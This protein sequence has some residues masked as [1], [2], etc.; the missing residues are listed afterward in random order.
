MSGAETEMTVEAFSKGVAIPY[1]YLEESTF[2]EAV[3]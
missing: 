2:R 1:P 3:T